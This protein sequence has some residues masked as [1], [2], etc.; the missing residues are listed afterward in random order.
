MN[1]TRTF[2]GIT[3][4]S[5]LSGLGA[6]VAPVN[7]QGEN[8]A[9]YERTGSVLQ[10]IRER[11]RVFGR[12]HPGASD[13]DVAP[14]AS[15]DPLRNWKESGLWV[16]L[17]PE[18]CDP[19]AY[20]ALGKIMSEENPDWV[21]NG[22][23][24]PIWAASH[25]MT[26][27][28]QKESDRQYF[29][30]SHESA[31]LK[32]VDP[33][34]VDP[35]DRPGR[36]VWS[37]FTGVVPN[38]NHPHW[39]RLKLSQDV[40]RRNVGADSNGVAV[41]N[42]ALPGENGEGSEGICFPNDNELYVRD[43]R[44]KVTVDFD[45]TALGGPAGQAN[46]TPMTDG[47]GSFYFFNPSSQEMM[48]RVQNA[49]S[50]NDRIWLS[51]SGMTTVGTQT[52]FE[53]LAS[54]EQKEYS[55]VA[56]NQFGGFIDTDG[57]SSVACEATPPY[58]RP[59]FPEKSGTIDDLASYGLPTVASEA[60]FKQG[61]VV[62][63]KEALT[64][65]AIFNPN[66]SDK[67]AYAAPLDC[68]VTPEGF[69]QFCA[70]H[71]PSRNAW[72]VV[73]DEHQADGAG[74]VG[75]G[76]QRQ[77]LGVVVDFN[78]PGES[79]IVMY[80]VAGATDFNGPYTDFGVR[81]IRSEDGLR[82]DQDYKITNIDAPWALESRAPKQFVEDVMN[83]RGPVDNRGNVVEAPVGCPKDMFPGVTFNY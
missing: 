58:F 27:L 43:G 28:L 41:N 25:P 56:G 34:L 2:L 38:Q 30:T 65:Y 36:A 50:L 11:A 26:V 9:V 5:I 10:P 64:L 16:V 6:N 18:G 39:L 46:S 70:T 29:G 32:L 44:F 81:L 60:R 79:N 76:P 42:S 14:G 52:Q 47:S 4:A 13:N 31:T 49:C 37:Q 20:T 66:D 68:A 67:F 74:V 82:A 15:E 63:L 73:V 17:P 78:V 45:A 57:M 55:T 54:D 35:I 62:G 22:N 12:N 77:T 8:C 23:N 7:A 24:D 21:Q 80:Q 72:Y 59:R 75:N 83:C 51:A 69:A 1:K 3:L 48:V 40:A 61:N 71:A 33:V 53:D 19:S